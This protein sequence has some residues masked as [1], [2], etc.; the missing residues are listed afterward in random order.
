MKVAICEF[1]QET[2][3][4]NPVLSGMKAFERGGIYDGDRFHEA[5]YGKQLAVA[6]MIKELEKDGVEPI[7]LYSMNADSGGPVEDAVVNFF[8]D[9][10]IGLL[11]ESLPLDGLLVSLHGATHSETVDDVCGLILETLRKETGH[12]TLIAAS[13]DLHANI[14]DKIHYNA[15]FICGYQ[16]YPHVD[17]FGTG[18]RAARMLLDTLSGKIHARTYRTEIP[19]IAPASSYTTLR[20][21]FG[22]L[23]L[24]A[25]SLVDTG[26]ILDYTIF[27][28]QPWLDVKVG[29]SSIITIGEDA[30]GAKAA[31]MDLARKLYDM[32]DSFRQNLLS[33]DEVIRKAENNKTGKPVVLVDSPDSPNAGACGD[34]PALLERI[35]ALDSDVSAAFYLN[36]GIAVSKLWNRDIGS[37]QRVSL[38][39]SLCD[40]YYKPVELEVEILSKHNGVFVAEGPSGKGT[41]HDCGRVV[42]VRWRN[43]D[44]VILENISFPGDLQIY[45]HFGVEPT[46]FQL[47]NVKACTSFRVAYEPIAAAICE[48]DTPGTAPINLKS[49]D[50][51]RLPKSFYPFSSIDDYVIPEAVASERASEKWL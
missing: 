42:T 2:D 15:D 49:L 26:R 16:T 50:F 34:S 30:A 36:D 39:A 3:S 32:R 21:A 24:Y 28:M 41:L 33:I 25:H 17:F 27:Q 14:T 23:M 48:A 5:V 4:F 19:M 35:K 37:I 31:A 7:M 44:I 9:K 47:V 51:Q 12:K 45:R 1:R 46:F 40:I 11:R 6:G 18:A 29:G 22:R 43:V 13:F 20:G 8:M 38:G 10:T